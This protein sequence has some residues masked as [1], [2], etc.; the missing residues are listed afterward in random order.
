MQ[1]LRA[2]LTALGSVGV[3][4]TDTDVAPRLLFGVLGRI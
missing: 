2:L 3:N 1:P 4:A